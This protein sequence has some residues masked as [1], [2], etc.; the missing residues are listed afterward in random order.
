ML[1]V[2]IPVTF[3]K[4]TRRQQIGSILLLVGFVIFWMRGITGTGPV[5]RAY[6]QDLAGYV[7]VYDTHFDMYR[8]VKPEE[9]RV[10]AN[11]TYALDLWGNQIFVGSQVEGLSGNMCFGHPR[12]LDTVAGYLLSGVGATLGL[13]GW[14][15]D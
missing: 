13:T 7:F 6:P 2:F 5:C 12:Y 9:P 14:H 3:W 4:G 11:T 15:D 8:I 10:P 1:I